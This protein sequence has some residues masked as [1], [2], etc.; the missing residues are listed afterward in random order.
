L[1]DFGLATNYEVKEYLF[2]RCGTPGFVAPEIIL[3]P[4]N[5]NIHYDCKCDIFSIGIIFYILLS[6]KNPFD[7]KTFKEILKKNRACK[8]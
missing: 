4:S 1:V 8:I 6:K 7:G 3:A 5:Q 2:K